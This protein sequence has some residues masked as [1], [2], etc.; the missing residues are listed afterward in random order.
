MK[1]V[2]LATAPE[3]G[4]SVTDAPNPLLLLVETSNPAGAVTTTEPVSAAPETENDVVEDAVPYVVV[5]AEVKVST[6]A[7]TVGT[8]GATGVPWTAA[9][10]V[11]SPA[12]FTARIFTS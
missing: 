10:S 11:P 4:D 5:S 6:E 8:E 3:A 1:M 9:L 12:L 2:V 7:R